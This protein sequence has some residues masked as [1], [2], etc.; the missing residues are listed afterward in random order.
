MSERLV[1]MVAWMRVRAVEG[2]EVCEF[3][4][5]SRSTSTVIATGTSIII[6]I[7]TVLVGYL[8]CAGRC[9]NGLMCI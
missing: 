3:K 9:V 6:T 1:V 2:E 8:L 4:I 5:S 7:A